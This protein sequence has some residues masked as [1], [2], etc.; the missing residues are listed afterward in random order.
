MISKFKNVLYGSSNKSDDNTAVIRTDQY[1]DR[2]A[3]FGDRISAITRS[4]SFREDL[5]GGLSE[6]RPDGSLINERSN[7][8]TNQIPVSKDDSHARLSNSRFKNGLTEEGHR[9]VAPSRSNND[10][11]YDSNS[12]TTKALKFPYTR[13]EFLQLKTDDEIFVSADHQIRPIIL[14][15]DVTRLPWKAGYAECINAGKSLRNEDQ[16]ACYQDLAFERPAASHFEPGNATGGII[17][18]GDQIPWVYFGIFDGHA[19]AA[20]AVTAAAQL[21]HIIGEKLNQIADLLIALEFGKSLQIDVEDS[22]DEY[23]DCEEKETSSNN[24]RTAYGQDSRET[25]ER[26]M[27][28]ESCQE[29]E[30]ASES[31]K[32]PNLEDTSDGKISSEEQ[33]KM[34]SS[35][36]TESTDMCYSSKL[37]PK[38]RPSSKVIDFRHLTVTTD[39][40]ITGALESAFLDMDSMIAK[41][42]LNYKMPGGCTAIVSLF[43]LGKLYVCNA[44]DSRAIVYKNSLMT[45]MSFDFTPTSE[46]AR[47]LKLGQQRPDLMGTDFTQLEFIRRPTRADLGK[48]MLYRD[49]Y[50]TGWSMKIIYPEDLRIPLVWGEGKRSR[51]LATIGVTRGFGDHELRTQY[52]S[53][54]IKPFLTAEPEVKIL[55]LE[56]DETLTAEDVLIM[57]TDGLW[58][59]IS[60]QE[61]ANIVKNS[62]ELFPD[63]EESRSKYRYITAAQDLVIQSR[64]H[65]DGNT[66]NIWRTTDE[67][68]ASL[69]DIAVFV[70]PLKQYKDEYVAWKRLHL[71]SLTKIVHHSQDTLFYEFH[72]HKIQSKT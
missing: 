13:P 5:T 67:R 27:T 50:M 29:I 20:V 4:S 43:I 28:S 8:K 72:E 2:K 59:V 10:F 47:I 65:T 12:K 42:K 49:A 63:S 36:S 22:G 19:G 54:L 33:P 58:D 9:R 21:H 16:A 57:G 25:D 51:V 30:P 38:Y 68:M 69:D 1:A 15:R 70:I 66:G 24:G 62:F 71:E 11:H 3:L 60:N 64:G 45:P 52:G 56:H 17:P 41:D 46:K 39:S 48:K 14:P 34:T 32:P 53:V 18:F 23:K 55:P 7:S 61:A 26:S 44:G 40:L 35:Q 37:S 31:D 6:R